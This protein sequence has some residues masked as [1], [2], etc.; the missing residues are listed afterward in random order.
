[1]TSTSPPRPVP[2]GLRP[3]WDKKV[4]EFVDL[5]QPEIE[6]G[7][8]ERHRL[9]SL[10]LMAIV[11]SQMNGNKYGATGDY[12]R[13]RQKQVLTQLPT[14]ATLYTG[15]TYL[16][17]NIAAL[18]VDADGRVIDFDF[19][20]NQIFN[21]SVE[22][23]ESRLIRRLFSL[24]EILDPL[25]V[26][27]ATPPSE[28]V[29]S[30]R[31][32]GAQ[33][34]TFSLAVSRSPMEEA[35]SAGVPQFSRKSYATMLTDVTLYTSLES[36]AQC[37]GIM[38]L[39]D[40][41]DVVYLQY[42]NGQFYIGNIMYQATADPRYPF[43][44]AFPLSG[45]LF[46]FEYYARFNQANAAFAQAV[47]EEPFFQGPHYVTNTPSIT[48]FLCTDAAADIYQE[49]RDELQRLTSTSFPSYRRPARDGR[50]PDTALTNSE[51]LTEVQRFYS[52][53]LLEGRRGT[54]HRV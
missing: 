8:Q 13:W 24:A 16:G 47:V 21:S 45:D 40:V 35:F 34:R 54:S 48:S 23:A 9:F 17:H 20:H 2:S 30:S 42:D 49:G 32:I 38:C 50:I 10:L 18:A 28:H 52:Y 29:G 27:A 19:N 41:R 5:P 3:Y 39:A 46:A 31:A 44:S 1:M 25:K 14:G 22:H 33:P 43:R 15:G 11:S 36:C 12:G 37:S 26:A 7:L 4:S 6:D 53:A 51:V